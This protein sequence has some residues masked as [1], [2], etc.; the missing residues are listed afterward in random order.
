MEGYEGDGCLKNAVYIVV[1]GR[2]GGITYNV[3]SYIGISRLAERSDGIRGRSLNVGTDISRRVNR[4]VDL[5]VT[6]FAVSV[7]T[8]SDKLTASL[9]SVLARLYAYRNGKVGSLAKARVVLEE[10]LSRRERCVRSRLV[11]L[12]RVRRS[13]SVL[14]NVSDGRRAVSPGA[15]ASSVCAELGIIKLAECGAGKALGYLMTGILNASFL[16]QCVAGKNVGVLIAI[17]I[18]L[19]VGSIFPY[20]NREDLIGSIIIGISDHKFVGYFILCAEPSESAH[21]DNCD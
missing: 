1:Y 17:L 2:N 20:V 8:D 13:V 18:L 16:L 6:R 14:V 4:N 19:T 21:R 12:Y 11:T 9:L 5:V 7:V 15:D 10:R 3:K